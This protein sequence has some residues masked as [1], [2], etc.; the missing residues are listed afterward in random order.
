MNHLQ[1]KV[2][3]NRYALKY[4]GRVIA[5][6]AMSYLGGCA[7]AVPRKWRATQT[8]PRSVNF[9]VP[10]MPLSDRISLTNRSGEAHIWH[11]NAIRRRIARRSEEVVS[12]IDAN[13]C[14]A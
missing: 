13:Q 8:Q 3:R 4:P 7:K 12:L 14:F 2:E 9:A 5:S 1:G 10:F 6:I 11:T